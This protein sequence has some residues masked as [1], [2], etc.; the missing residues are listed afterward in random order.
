MHTNLVILKLFYKS[1]NWLLKLSFFALPVALFLSITSFLFIN[2][3]LNSYEKYLI[4]SYIGV[5][6]RL[7]VESKDNKFIQD[8]S[9]F[10]NEKHLIFSIKAQYKTNIFF[11]NSSKT[12]L[13]FANFY[14][15]NKSYL[16]RKFHIK[17]D[18][19]TIF[20]NK[21]F[22]S[23]L[24]SLDI[25]SFKTLF[26]DKKYPFKIKIKVVDTG[27]LGSTPMIFITNSFAKHIFPVSKNL[28]IEFLKNYNIKDNIKNIAK[29]DKVLS[30]KIHDIINDTKDTK[31][32]FE[33]IN[34]IQTAITLLLT[35]LSL[36]IIILSISISIEF[37]RNSLN[38]L[39]LI[40]MSKRD[41]GITIF[42]MIF[43]MI[44]IVLGFSVVSIDIFRD[45]FLSITHFEHFF[46][47]INYTL[48]GIIFFCGVLL[49]ILSYVSTQIIFK[50][51]L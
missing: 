22:A 39:Q 40:G 19:N 41:L 48:V 12:I 6:G 44:T 31:A 27:F 11:Q 14:A 37:K 15:L 34:L 28:S 3:L 21:V 30:F 17:I 47:P 35:L 36:G 45:M 49:S 43:I 25:Y 38:V 20:V 42:G 8:I 18:D 7:S 51:R 24:G 4:N 10:S 9:K 13:K 16:E 2:N 33:K 46:I 5:Q 23:S 50:G 1:S 29:Q 32:F 26:L